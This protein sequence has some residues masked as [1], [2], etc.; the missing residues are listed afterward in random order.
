MSL[1]PNHSWT[2]TTTTY[3]EGDSF[4]IR[5]IVDMLIVALSPIISLNIGQRQRDLLR[6][7]HENLALFQRI[8]MKEPH[9]NHMKWVNF[10]RGS[11][12]RERKPITLF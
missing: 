3:Q 6:I 2:T 10:Q 4:Y 9:Y 1:H 8:Q 7:A 12:K 11:R 5:F